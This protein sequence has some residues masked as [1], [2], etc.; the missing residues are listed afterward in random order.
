MHKQSKGGAISPTLKRKTAMDR[1]DRHC[2]CPK[3]GAREDRR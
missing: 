3:V 1:R 2:E